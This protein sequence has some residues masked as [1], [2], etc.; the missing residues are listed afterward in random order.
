MR[1]L[2]AS[3]EAPPSA[4]QVEE[5]SRSGEITSR[6]ASRILKNTINKR[7]ADSVALRAWAFV[8]LKM[9]HHANDVLRDNSA[10]V[11]ASERVRFE[12]SIA[13]LNSASRLEYVNFITKC[14][15]MD[16]TSNKMFELH[17]TNLRSVGGGGVVTN[18]SDREN[19]DLRFL[20]AENDKPIAVVRL[21]REWL[22]RACADRAYKQLAEQLQTVSE[23]RLC[24]RWQ[25]VVVISKS[26]AQ[27]PLSMEILSNQTSDLQISRILLLPKRELFNG[28]DDQ[29]ESA[30]EDLILEALQK[31]TAR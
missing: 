4:T 18:V 16:G 10:L 11:G 28:N 20:P 13:R 31:T 19:L 23:L 21:S 24:A 1:L 3:A 27:Q 22:L 12:A 29:R 8:L 15:L 9:P 5:E 25:L 17:L 6:M 30:R 26:T 2:G 14:S 7:D